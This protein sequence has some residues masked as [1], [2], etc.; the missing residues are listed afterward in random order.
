[1]D[2]SDVKSKPWQGHT[3]GAAT[4]IQTF[5][6]PGKEYDL[7]IGH[8]WK[9]VSNFYTQNLT[10]AF[11]T[12]AIGTEDLISS[13][14][15]AFD[16]VAMTDIL[17]LLYANEITSNVNKNINTILDGL[18]QTTSNNVLN[19]KV[20]GVYSSIP[21]VKS[22]VTEYY[23]AEKIFIIFTSSSVYVDELMDNLI[24]KEIELLNEF[25]EETFSFRYIPYISDN[26]FKSQ[27]SDKAKILFGG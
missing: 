24:T 20:V 6:E 23:L 14:I 18:L 25:P 11:T 4:G 17:K 1:M 13:T 26:L 19:E 27:L 10:N 9:L 15:K 3:F 2:I 12:V 5:G 22:V 21:E 16:I 7:E 8:A